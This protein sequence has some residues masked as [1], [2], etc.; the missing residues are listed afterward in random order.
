MNLLPSPSPPFHP[1]S[2]GVQGGGSPPAIQTE[3]KLQ[4]ELQ[5]FP[6]QFHSYD[7]NTTVSETL[8]FSYCVNYFNGWFRA[9]GK[10]QKL[11]I[12]DLNFLLR[13]VEHDRIRDVVK[14]L[15]GR[16]KSK[17]FDICV[18]CFNHFLFTTGFLIK[19]NFVVL[20]SMPSTSGQ[21]KGQRKS[22]IFD[23]FVFFVLIIFF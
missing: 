16:R 7:R 1:K 13:E 8:L 4:N 2:G 11:S 15:R 5:S 20:I 23:I 18:F 19:T 6:A 12:H 21:R 3:C 17:I 9:F 10:R 14:I 22:N